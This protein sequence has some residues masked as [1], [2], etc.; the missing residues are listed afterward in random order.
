[1]H[2]FAPPRVPPLSK[3]GINNVTNQ[4]ESIFSTMLHNLHCDPHNCSTIHTF[5]P[6]RV[7]PLSKG[8][9]NNVTT[10]QVESNFFNNAQIWSKETDTPDTH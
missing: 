3:G 6:P 9:I 10:V 5:A 4:V 7:P 2:T 1:M 8:G